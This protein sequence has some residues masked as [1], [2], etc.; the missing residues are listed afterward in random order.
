[1]PDVTI[2]LRVVGEDLQVLDQ[3]GEKIQSVG[4]AGEQS[5]SG[6]QSLVSGA[7]DMKGGV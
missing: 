7:T 5:K 2:K 1:L 4:Q 6:L 3:A